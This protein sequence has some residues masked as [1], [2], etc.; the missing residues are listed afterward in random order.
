MQQNKQE[1]I[2]PVFKYTLKS[3]RDGWSGQKVVVYANSPIEA[4]EK[5]NLSIGKTAS[6]G[7]LWNVVDDIEEALSLVQKEQE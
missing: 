1:Q 5:A 4:Y 3:H 7:F 6:D 2:K